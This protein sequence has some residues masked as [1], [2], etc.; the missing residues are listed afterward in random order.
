MLSLVMNK[1]EEIKYFHDKQLKMREY[2]THFDFSLNFY[3]LVTFNSTV[4][5]SI[6]SCIQKVVDIFQDTVDVTS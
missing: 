1:I 3:V 5:S 2:S 6:M 4:P